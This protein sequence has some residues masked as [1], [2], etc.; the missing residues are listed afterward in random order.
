MGTAPFRMLLAGAALAVHVAAIAQGAGPFPEPSDAHLRAGRTVWLGT[1]RDCHGNSMSDAPTV[2][3][4]KDWQ[5]RLARGRA[6][7]YASAL[8][9]RKGAG[10]TEMPA[11]GGNANL[12]DDQVRAAVD[13]MVWLVEPRKEMQ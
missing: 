6:A 4:T 8:G 3:N 11:R 9:G 10:G 7:L 13:Y 1:C 2:K 5:P 12:T